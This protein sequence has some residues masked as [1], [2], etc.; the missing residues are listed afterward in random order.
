MALGKR[1]PVG[2]E[3]AVLEHLMRET[4]K[5]LGP[6]DVV[7]GK[8]TLEEFLELARHMFDDLPQQKEDVLGPVVTGELDS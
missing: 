8:P 7:D 6:V 5:E 1:A 3:S 4:P 2:G